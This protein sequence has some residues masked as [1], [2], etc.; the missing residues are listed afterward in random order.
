MKP[1]EILAEVLDGSPLQIACGY[2]FHKQNDW[3]KE[4]CKHLRYP[5][6]ECW[7]KY[8]EL[9]SEEEVPWRE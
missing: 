7:L 9:K 8:A 3:C 6:K 5:D 2:L 4:H 1:V